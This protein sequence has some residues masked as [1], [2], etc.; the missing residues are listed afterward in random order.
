MNFFFNKM[1]KDY[2]KKI[3][4]FFNIGLNPSD[5]FS[6]YR[7]II[8]GKSYM[9]LTHNFF[10][11]KKL[12]INNLTGDL[13][14]CAKNNYNQFIF[15]DLNLIKNFD[16]YKSKKSTIKLNLKKNFKLNIL[17]I[18]I[19]PIFI[20]LNKIFYFASKELKNYYCSLIKIK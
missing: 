3:I 19:S 2:K 10:F 16:F 11:K 13:G 5:E 17:R 20:L 14:E 15:K 9:R 18:I 1:F 12:I 4:D 6:L 8:T 7:Q